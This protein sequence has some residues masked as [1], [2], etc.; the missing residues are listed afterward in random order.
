MLE[1]LPLLLAFASPPAIA[2]TPGAASP[3][4]AGAP[5]LKPSDVAFMY[6]ADEAAYKAYG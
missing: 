3:A 2:E 4:S 5:V 6:A 1:M